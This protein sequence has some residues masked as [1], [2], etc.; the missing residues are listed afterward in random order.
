VCGLV[1]TLKCQV[2]WI[3]DLPFQPILKTWFCS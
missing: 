2:S 3:T 1:P